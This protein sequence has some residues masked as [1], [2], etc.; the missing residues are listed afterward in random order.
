MRIIR[1]TCPNQYMVLMKFKSQKDAD[2]FY[3][4]NNNKPFN[5]IEDNACHLV[6]IE[7]VEAISSSKVIYLFSSSICKIVTST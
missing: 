2:E 4:Y 5:S 6:Y 1:D 7:S 3:K